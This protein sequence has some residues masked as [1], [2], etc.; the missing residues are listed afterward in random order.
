MNALKLCV[1]AFEVLES[2]EELLE[3]LELIETASE[4]VVVSLEELEAVY[5]RTGGEEEPPASADPSAPGA[6]ATQSNVS[7]RH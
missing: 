5:D 4:K 7:R 2:H 6:P 1:S 3:F